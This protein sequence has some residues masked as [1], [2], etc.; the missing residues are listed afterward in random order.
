V[1]L[2]GS[3]P[4]AQAIEEIV[5]VAS[6]VPGVRSVASRLEVRVRSLFRDGA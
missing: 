2:F 4:S 3:A 5:R 6:R 1:T